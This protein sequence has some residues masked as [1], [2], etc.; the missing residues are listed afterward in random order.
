MDFETMIDNVFKEAVPLG[1]ALA[2]L[3]YLYQRAETS[4]AR[5]VLLHAADYL[6]NPTGYQ[7]PK[8]VRLTGS[9]VRRYRSQAQQKMHIKHYRRPCTGLGTGPTSCKE[10]RI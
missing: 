8:R 5:R 9:A 6:T 4:R 3:K 1:Q 10:P 7:R 2:M